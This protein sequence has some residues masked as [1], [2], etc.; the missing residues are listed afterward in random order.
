MSSRSHVRVE[1]MMRGAWPLENCESTDR[2]PELGGHNLRVDIGCA[3]GDKRAPSLATS[4]VPRRA[5]Q[6]VVLTSR[7]GGPMIPPPEEATMTD[8]NFPERDDEITEPDSPSSEEAVEDLEDTVSETDAN[9]VTGGR[10][11]GGGQQEFI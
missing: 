11:A 4:V 3:Q 10:K 1:V 9:S 7:A 2:L 6:V 5:G 8:P